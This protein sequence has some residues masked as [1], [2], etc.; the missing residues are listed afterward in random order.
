MRNYVL[1]LQP[2]EQEAL[3]RIARFDQFIQ[4]DTAV[5]AERAEQIAPARVVSIVQLQWSG[6]TGAAVIV[7]QPL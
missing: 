2:L 1:C 7:D 5:Q 4:Q 3:E 6:L